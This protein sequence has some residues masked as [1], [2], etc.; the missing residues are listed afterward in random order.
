MT[1]GEQNGGPATHTSPPPG[2]SVALSFG[3]FKPQSSQ[4]SGA[5][6]GGRYKIH[7]FLSE[8][9]T[10]RVYLAEDVQTGSAVVVKMLTPNAARSLELRECMEREAQAALAIRHPN[11]VAVL[12]SG[13]TGGG[14]PYVVMEALLGESLDEMLGRRGALPTDLA[15]TLAR[16]AAAALAATHAAGIVHRDVKPGNLL[17]LG[18]PERPY[19]LKLLDYGMA[20]LGPNER[21]DRNTVLGTLEYIAPEQIVVEDVDQRADIYAFGVVLFRLL[22]G[23]LPFDNSAGPMVLRHQLFSPMPPPTW[24]DETL[25]PRLEAIILNATRKDPVNRYASMGEVI[26]DLEAVLGLSSNEVK[27]RPLTREP[28]LYEPRSERGREALEV[29]SRK[30]GRYASVPP[31]PPRP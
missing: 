15:L 8:G 19:G 30:F 16:Q 22:T 5:V 13:E 20:R 27:L 25:D 12:G 7:G 10:S 2:A 23:H 17:V 4:L 31:P 18:A 29:L 11:V 28:D 9:A 14:L 1:V 21:T 26:S 6:L 3:Q 24:L